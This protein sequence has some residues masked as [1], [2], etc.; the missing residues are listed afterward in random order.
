MR[1]YLNNEDVEEYKNYAGYSEE[2]NIIMLMRKKVADD[3]KK[4]FIDMFKSIEIDDFEMVSAL[5]ESGLPLEV[6]FT[7]KNGFEYAKFKAEE[8]GEYLETLVMYV[9][10]NDGNNIHLMFE[11]LGPIFTLV[12]P[13]ILCKEFG[14]A[15]AF[16][17]GKGVVDVEFFHEDDD[18]ND[19]F[20]KNLID[21]SKEEQMQFIYTYCDKV[22]IR[23]EE[24]S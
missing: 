1:I 21:K 9:N 18:L 5:E 24:V 2:Y 4:M 20:T 11:E 23:N 22:V 10:L 14:N 12:S 7:S 13:S 6:H 19:D 8:L 3:K 15:I 16:M 17:I